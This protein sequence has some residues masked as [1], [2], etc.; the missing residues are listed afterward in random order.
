[1]L[2]LPSHFLRLR[3]LVRMRSK[4]I[5][6]VG[7]GFAGVWAAVGAVATLRGAREGNA[8]SVELVSPD[9]WLVMRPRLYESDLSGV[10]VPLDAVL[11]PIGVTYRR[12]RVIEIDCV[13]RSVH[14]DDGSG[15]LGYDE[16]IVATGSRLVL[17]NGPPVHAVDTHAQATA[18]H[19]ELAAMAGMPNAGF[20]AVVVGAGFTG[21]EVAAELAGMLERAASAARQRG[22]SRVT[23]VERGGSLAPEFG[24][25]AR[26]VI[27]RS[28]ESLGVEVR[29]GAA[30][31]D[32]RSGGV[33]LT[34]G[35]HVD[36]ELVVWSTGPRACVLTE[37][38]PSGRDPLGRLRVNEHLATGV[39]GI[40][41]AGDSACA[42]VDGRHTS[43]MS[44]QHAMPQ[45]RQAG[46]NAAA[47][48]LGKAPRRYQQ[49]LYLTC[50]DLGAAGA[51]LTCGFDRDTMLATGE[52]AKAFKRY[53]NRSVIYPPAN[54]DVEQILSAARPA[55]A[56]RAIA[57]VSG[58]ALRS[59][60]VRS[61]VID[62]GEDRATQFAAAE[63]GW[64]SEGVTTAGASAGPEVGV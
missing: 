52:S 9:S 17:P 62:A 5:L 44:C 28:L 6:I 34:D 39:D 14:L 36:G 24:S 64:P 33:T 4:R 7:G 48:A 27:E 12:G 47:A 19:R 46:E 26:K 61:R 51:L 58:L 60:L 16:L 29:T 30:V 8:V 54:A 20:S 41:A 38:V 15:P 42:A 18:L 56:G 23:L 3:R 1:M 37:Q 40:W 25:Q 31:S 11:A 10:R 21:I 32:V 22:R 2:S 59:R 43:V 57:T 13:R 45:G 53:I 63:A 49:P 50:L 35:S 55:P